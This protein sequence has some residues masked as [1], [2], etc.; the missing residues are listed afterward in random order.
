MVSQF[1]RYFPNVNSDEPFKRILIEDELRIQKL[2]KIIFDKVK[3][4]E[5]NK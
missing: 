3:E 4:V 1:E 2:E 5:I